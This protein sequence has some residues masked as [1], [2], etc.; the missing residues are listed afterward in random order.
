MFAKKDKTVSLI[1]KCI[2]VIAAA[3]G[4]LLSAGAGRGSFMGGAWWIIA[5]FVLL[6]LTGLAYLALLNRRK[7][8]RAT[9]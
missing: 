4:V 7:K 2:T 6:M 5:L 9:A 3:V 1:L 8:R